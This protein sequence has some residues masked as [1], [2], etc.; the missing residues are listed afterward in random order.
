MGAGLN[1]SVFKRGSLF[2]GG[3]AKLGDHVGLVGVG[4]L[5]VSLGVIA[6]PLIDGV[7]ANRFKG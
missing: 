5:S 4:H 6:L 2:E 1:N 7:S 3:S